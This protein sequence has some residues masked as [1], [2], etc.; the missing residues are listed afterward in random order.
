MA[1]FHEYYSGARIA[2][3]LTVFIGGN[4]EAS[5][6]LFELYY[7]G[8][9][10]PN[11]YYL[12]A[13]NVLR[14]GPLR[15][16]G[17]SGI[18]KPYDYNKPHF[19]RLPYS[20]RDIGSIYHVRS[21]D[22]RKLLAV[23]SQIDIGLSHDWPQGI[24]MLGDHQWLF[25]SKPG[26]QTDSISG[27]LGS[28]AARNCLEYLRPHYWFSAHLHTKYVAIMHHDNYKPHGGSTPVENKPFSK[29]SV[30]KHDTGNIDQ[31]RDQNE[32]SAWQQFGV[33]AQRAAAEENGQILRERESRRFEEAPAG[34]HRGPQYVFEETFKQVASSDDLARNVI[35][36]TLNQVDHNQ[37]DLGESS[38]VSQLDGCV[39]SRPSKKQRLHSP[40]PQGNDQGTLNTSSGGNN[41]PQ[42]TANPDAIDIEM[43]DEEEEVDHPPIMEKVVDPSEGSSQA[44]DEPTIQT[45]AV[46]QNKAMNDNSY[47]SEDGGVELNSKASSSI[48]VPTAA[49]PLE[50]QDSPLASPALEDSE[51]PS[52]VKALEQPVDA[53]KDVDANANANAKPESEVSEEMRAQLA[54]L[55]ETFSQREEVTTSP[56][57][58]HPETITNKTT[59]FLALGKCEPFQEFLQLLEVKSITEP[60]GSSSL[61]R[62][63]KLSYDPEWL[64]IQ[65]VFASELSLGGHPNHRAPPH[66]G[67]TYYR[68]EIQRESEWINE[69]VVKADKLEVPLNFTITSPVYDP[70]LHVQQHEMPREVSNPQTQAYCDLIGIEN[71]FDISEEERDARIQQGPRPGED[72]RGGARD[73]RDGDGHRGRGGGGYGG[74]G[75]G[76]FGSGHRGGGRGRGRG[77]GRGRGRYH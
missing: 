26:F 17:L 70:G 76:G 9:V 34:V 62:P 37:Q 36:T 41:P 29:N 66:R 55:S 8:W 19:E 68:D 57:L 24:E 20:E 27:R 45:P 61:V 13:A 23:R 39:S 51:P 28:V 74:R 64:A 49:V 30:P 63:L 72:D 75:R 25:R 32:I 11:I 67:D 35:S 71:K 7:G 54:A 1:D 60:E 4:H 52:Q 38:T 31:S 46:D 59:H 33:G 56:A 12:G 18:W 43:S 58:P 2:P 77:G 53:V 3:Y 48:P 73:R 50:H 6:H 15:I 69:H 40:D 42:A 47:E 14:F 65:R 21:V 10:A 16:G 22:V 5:N 44:R